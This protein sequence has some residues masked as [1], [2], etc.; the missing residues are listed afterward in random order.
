MDNLEGSL[1]RLEA[2][3]AQAESRLRALTEENAR[4]RAALG[5]GQTSDAAGA[6]HPAGRSYRLAILE[7]ERQEIRARIRGVIEAL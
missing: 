3:V 2:L 1:S 5:E 4:L 7:A 6:E